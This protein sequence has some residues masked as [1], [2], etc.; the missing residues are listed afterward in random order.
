MSIDDKVIVA[1]A[2]T[3][4][5]GWLPAGLYGHPQAGIAFGVAAVVL[6]YALAFMF[7]E[8]DFNE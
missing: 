2:A 8:E 1:H 3:F 6:Q 7:D 4:F 5:A